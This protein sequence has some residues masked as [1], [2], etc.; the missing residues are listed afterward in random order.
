MPLRARLRPTLFSRTAM[1]AS[2][3]PS[4]SASLFAPKAGEQLTLSSTIPLQ[5]GHAQPRFGIGAW[6]MRGDEA[7]TALKHAFDVVGYRHVDTARYYR[8]ERQVGQAIRESKVP[9]EALY[10]T[11]K[12]FTND[13][14]GGERT[15]AAYEDSLNSSGLA[16]WDLVLLHAPDGGRAH[17]LKTWAALSEYVKAGTIRSLGVS[18][19]GEHHIDELMNSAEGQAVKP[20]VN[21][22][23]CHPFFAQTSLRRKCEENGIAVQGY[24]P[25]A[26][27]RYYGDKTLVDVAKRNNCSEAQ[28]MLRWAIQQGIVPLPKSSNEGRQTENA[29]T[30]QLNL[31]DDDMKGA[32]RR[33]AGFFIAWPWC[34]HWPCT[35]TD[36]AVSTHAP[37]P[38]HRHPHSSR[39]P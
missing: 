29:Q 22:I 16:Y 21:Q 23:E 34:A 15:K 14:G 11:T 2:G 26:R 37:P 19:F 6:L 3:P 24:C 7:T 35:L 1:S 27:G 36:K 28:V 20:V 32:S 9:R 33:P 12:L 4:S 31:S 10:A 25:L 17:R 18:N 8:N 39:R 13:M 5:D 38:F 30:L